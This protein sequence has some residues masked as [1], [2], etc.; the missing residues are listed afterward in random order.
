MNEKNVQRRT[1]IAVYYSCRVR[2]AFIL[3]MTFES[4]K[5]RL[6]F[7]ERAMKLKFWE[8]VISSKWTENGKD[9]FAIYLKKFHEPRKKSRK[10]GKISQKHA[11][12]TLKMSLDWTQMPPL[13]NI[14]TWIIL[15]ESSNTCKVLLEEFMSS[16]LKFSDIS[17]LFCAGS[18][19]S[20]FWANVHHLTLKY[21][22]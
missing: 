4:L 20:F 2:K 10:F 3:K 11:Y 21:A 13:Q 22:G 15:L 8:W 6:W 5:S 9:M 17:V 19:V 1:E 16:T 18:F 12:N 14:E 7:S